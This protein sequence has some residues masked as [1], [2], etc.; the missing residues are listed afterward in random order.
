MKLPRQH[1]AEH[2]PA[3]EGESPLV[4]LGVG[5]GIVDASSLGGSGTEAGVQ[6]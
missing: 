5:C 3:S 1:G 4:S 6:A 2:S